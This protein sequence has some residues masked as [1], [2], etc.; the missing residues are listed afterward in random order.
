MRNYILLEKRFQLRV[1]EVLLIFYVAYAKQ[2]R[3]ACNNAPLH[4]VQCRLKHINNTRRHE[5]VA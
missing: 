2:E 5:R 1:K 3:L 4:K